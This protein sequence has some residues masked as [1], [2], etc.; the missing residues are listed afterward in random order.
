[1]ALI[2]VVFPKL[3]AP[4]NVVRYM[5]QNLCFRGTFDRQ[6]GK[7]VET[8]LQSERKDLSHIYHLE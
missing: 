1:M 7:W 8:L 5:S 3:R 6:H 2:A 4:R